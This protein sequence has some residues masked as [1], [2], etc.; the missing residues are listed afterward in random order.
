MRML[1]G[2]V[3]MRC[4]KTKDRELRSCAFSV[5]LLSYVSFCLCAPSWGHC[6]PSGGGVPS[7]PPVRL[8][9][10][11]SSDPAVAGVSRAPLRDVAADS[12]LPVLPR[13][14]D[15][16]FDSLPMLDERQ[17]AERD[18]IDGVAERFQ[19]PRPSIP[20]PI[21]IPLSFEISHAQITK[22]PIANVK[23]AQEHQPTRSLEIHV[24]FSKH[25][26]L[27]KLWGRHPRP[28]PMFTFL[29]G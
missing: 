9:K 28:P 26:V 24:K 17:F 11:I 19:L 21:G 18:I 8:Q 5:S 29:G 10:R 3:L 2:Q 1:S 20:I 12:I 13:V 7:R 27:L 23:L 6:A 25:I 16:H 22:L 14:D 4:G 15:R